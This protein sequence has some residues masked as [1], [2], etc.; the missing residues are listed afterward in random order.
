MLLIAFYTIPHYAF[1]KQPKTTI[2]QN[3]L[4]KTF[5]C[6]N[7]RFS[8]KKRKTERKKE[9]DD[10]DDDDGG[11]AASQQLGRVDRPD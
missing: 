2:S 5:F 9:V 11:R 3:I 6:T 8:A 10:G 7:R 1:S 4:F